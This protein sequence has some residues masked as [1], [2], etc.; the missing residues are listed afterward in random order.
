MFSSGQ[1]K[2]EMANTML[3]VWDLKA[4]QPGANLRAGGVAG[5]RER[6]RA[7]ESDS[8]SETEE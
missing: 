5:T 7:R 8:E 1:M 2:V 3:S 6:A 4:N